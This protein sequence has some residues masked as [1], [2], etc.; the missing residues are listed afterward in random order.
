MTA[1]TATPMN[2]SIHHAD[3]SGQRCTRCGAALVNVGRIAW[4]G[5]ETVVPATITRAA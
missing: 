1:N 5:R 3:T 2:C 4:L